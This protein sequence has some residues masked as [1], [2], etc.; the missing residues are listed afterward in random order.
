[1]TTKM[2]ILNGVTVKTL[3]A[4]QVDEAVASLRA[5]LPDANIVVIDVID[6]NAPTDNLGEIE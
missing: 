3:E 5:I 4:D 6:Q 2:I 1:M